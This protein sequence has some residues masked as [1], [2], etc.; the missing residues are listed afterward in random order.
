[1]KT[2]SKYKRKRALHGAETAH[3]RESENLKHSAIETG[4][5]LLI[6]V[7]GGGIAGAVIGKPALLIGVGVTGYGHYAKKPA[8]TT[9]GIGMMASGG[10]SG[11][12]T[13]QGVDGFNVEDVKARVMNFK[14]SITS[15]L[16]LDKIIK[17]KEATEKTEQTENGP[18]G[19]GEVQYF[20]Y[21][22][23]SKELDFSALDNLE[24]QIVKS[25]VAYQ[26]SIQGTEDEETV[27]GNFEE[28][29]DLSNNSY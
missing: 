6:G 24:K 26:K 25:G 2:K 29:L 4:K 14:D 20:T 19:V 18:N 10:F 12:N 3:K 28:V 22:N 16:F 15:R 21:P 17:K 8:L 5:D 1:M 27:Q 7:I 11:G 9:F 23:Q 13:T